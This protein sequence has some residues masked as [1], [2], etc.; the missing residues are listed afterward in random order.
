ML[1]SGGKNE[2]WAFVLSPPGSGKII[3]RLTWGDSTQSYEEED[4]TTVGLMVSKHQIFAEWHPSIHVESGLLIATKVV[5]QK[6]VL[7][8]TE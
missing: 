5:F 2:T 7:R 6:S 8:R 4:G 3:L 1:G